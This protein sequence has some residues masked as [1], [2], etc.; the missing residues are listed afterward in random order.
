MTPEQLQELVD[1][2]NL[3]EHDMVIEAVLVAKVKDFD[4]GATG[5]SMSATDDVEWVSQLG[6]LR[7]AEIIT[8]RDVERTSGED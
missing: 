4:T 7:A 6:M 8:T 2:L 3:N 5:I 1:A